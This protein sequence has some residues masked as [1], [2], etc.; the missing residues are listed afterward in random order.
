M[1]LFVWNDTE[2]PAWGGAC[3]YIIAETLEEAKRQAKITFVSKFGEA[4]NTINDIEILSEPDRVHEL[5]YAE[6]YWWK[7]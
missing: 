4:P 6:L 5:P 1:K 2:S 3:L 7:E